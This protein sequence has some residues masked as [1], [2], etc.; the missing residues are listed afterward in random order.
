VRDELAFTQFDPIW[1]QVGTMN[2]FPAE[3]QV[4][5]KRYGY[6]DWADLWRRFHQA[7]VPVFRHAQEAI[8][9]RD[10]ATLYEI[11]CFFALV[12]KIRQVLDLNQP[13]LTWHL[14]VSDEKGLEYTTW[15]TFGQTGYRLRYNEGFGRAEGLSYSVGLRP[16]YT[17]HG[18]NNL[19]IVFDAKFRF[20]TNDLEIDDSTDERDPQLT[21]KKSDLYKMHTYRDALSAK[22][23]VVIYPGSTEVFY[24][25]DATDSKKIDWEKLIK[26][27]NKWAG[28]GAVPMRPSN[29]QA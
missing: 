16:D 1:D 21:A 18:P 2:R 14:N 23:A 10:I 13:D 15:V 8:D 3:N 12:E 4:L 27:E 7:R 19:R 28:I 17:L 22:A 20:D 26:I 24:H 11:W 29:N 9:A 5:L 6:R 25:T